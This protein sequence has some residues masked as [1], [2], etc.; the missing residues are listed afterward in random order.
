MKTGK[1]TKE[2]DNAKRKLKAL[3]AD[4][5]ITYCETCGT[6]FGLSW[7]HSRKRRHIVG[8]ELYEVILQCLRCHQK[9][10]ADPNL[11]DK[12]R[13]VI[14][15]R[16]WCASTILKEKIWNGLTQQKKRLR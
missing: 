9:F 10:E 5:G 2:W 11:T 12:V 8:N 1:K 15:A 7:S 13:E 4:S 6:G 16:G 14:E 3:F